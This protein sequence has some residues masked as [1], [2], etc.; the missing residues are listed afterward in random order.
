MSVDTSTPPVS[1]A[2]R[3]SLPKLGHTA[4]RWLVLVGILVFWQVATS[5]MSSPFFPEPFRIFERAA[6]L[7]LPSG[8]GIITASMGRDVLPSLGR[9]LIGFGIAVVAGITVGVIIGLSHTIEA[10]LDWILQFMR[11]VP[12]PALFPV[13]L[14]ILGTGDSMRIALIA[15]G[16]IWP[17]LLNTIE[18]VR[19]VRPLTLDAARVFRI[20]SFDQLFRVMLPAA[21]PKIFAGVRTSLSLALILMVISEMVASSSGI[22]YQLVQAQRSFAILNMWASILLLAVLG[23]LLNL[24]LTVVERRILAWQ[25]LSGRETS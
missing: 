9:A 20:A 7:W 15:F 3:R 21:G 4:I 2:T 18:G 16:T 5:L 12:P 23:Y 17:I 13:F 14:I 11:A 25:R 24:A 19:G 10:Y 1:P 22:G 8:D 6:D